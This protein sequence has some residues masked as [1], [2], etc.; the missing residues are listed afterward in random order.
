ML[1]Y[2]FWKN[3]TLAYNSHNLTLLAAVTSVSPFGE[4]ATER[5]SFECFNVARLFPVDTS[6]SLAVSSSAPEARVVP[7]GEKMPERR[8]DAHAP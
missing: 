6:H 8:F 5:T 7:S 4:N 2:F 1:V 3:V